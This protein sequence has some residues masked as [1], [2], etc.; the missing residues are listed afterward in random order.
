MHFTRG[1]RSLGFTLIA[2][3]IDVHSTQSIYYSLLPTHHYTFRVCLSILNIRFDSFM[4]DF[5]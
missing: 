4:H 2:H 5:H 1:S 3:S